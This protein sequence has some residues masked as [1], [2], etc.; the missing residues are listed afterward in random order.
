M[1]S[2]AVGDSLSVSTS[3]V[4]RECDGPDGDAVPWEGVGRVTV[5]ERVSEWDRVRPGDTVAVMGAVPDGV[6]GRVVVGVPPVRDADAV[7]RLC[8][9]VFRLSDRDAVART[10]ALL[11][12][13]AV[14]VATGVSVLGATGIVSVTVR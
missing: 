9:A 11:L 6:S 8:V 3:D 4:D 13:G 10:D 1:V 14:F 12:R 5:R 7:P 2:D